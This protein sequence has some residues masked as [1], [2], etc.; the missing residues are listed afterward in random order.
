MSTQTTTNR[1]AARLMLVSGAA[2][3]V[4]VTNAANAQ[5]GA[6]D[7][8]FNL[9]YSIDIGSDRE[10][11]DPF[12]PGNNL[13]DPGDVYSWFRPL[14]AGP[15]DGFVIDDAFIFAGVDPAPD[16]DSG[17]VAPICFGGPIQQQA[18]EYF[19]LDGI[20]RIGLDLRE[21]I[22]PDGPNQQ[23]IPQFNAQCIYDLRLLVISFDD[24][25]GLNWLNCDVP[26]NSTSPAGLTY[27]TLAGD[28]EVIAISVAPLAGLVTSM[29]PWL[30]ERAVNV[31]LAS[32]PLPDQKF[33]DDVDALDINVNLA[34]DQC[35]NHYFTADHEAHYFDAAGAPIDPGSIYFVVPGLGPV[36]VIDDVVHLG[37]PESTDVDA[38]EFVWATNLLPGGPAGGFLAVVFS[39]D[40]DDPST[41]PDESGGLS[42]GQLYVS[43]FG[44]FSVPMLIDPLPDDID[45][46]A[47]YCA[48]P[49]TLPPIKCEGDINGDGAVDVNDLNIVLSQWLTGGPEGDLTEDGIVNVDDLNIVLAQWGQLCRC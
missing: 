46:I 14:M 30:G 1:M 37:I 33:D 11:S 23:P 17:T 48:D 29:T 25:R 19:D 16:D 34:A 10:L 3:A 7:P 4:G 31:N 38:F 21:F 13:M 40:D 24:D 32:T 35:F 44:G 41:P 43:Y 12:S 15:E 2:L 47:A 20:D 45:G 49:T 22:N 26:Q 9:E 8:C 5:V 6:C 18:F 28:D 42:P 39:V 36:K 27:G